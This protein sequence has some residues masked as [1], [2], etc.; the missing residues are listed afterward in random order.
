MQR[1]SA[2]ALILYAKRTLVGLSFAQVT[3][4]LGTAAMSRKRQH[5]DKWLRTASSTVDAGGEIVSRLTIRK[6]YSGKCLNPVY[7]EHR[8]AKAQKLY[9]EMHRPTNDNPTYTLELNARCRKCW[10]CRK[11]KSAF[12]RSRAIVEL[13][14]AKRS[15]FGTL[16]LREQERFLALSKARL[17]LAALGEDYDALPKERKFAELLK[18]I[19]PEVTKYWKRLRKNTSAT[20]KYLLVAE[21]HKD[22]MVHFHFLLHEV[23]GSVSARDMKYTWRLGFVQCKIIPLGDPRSA[24][25]V[26]KY[27]AKDVETRVKA[28]LGYG[29]SLPASSHSHIDQCDVKKSH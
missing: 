1:T 6:D 11:A 27:I 15:W 8:G 9:S 12:W 20:F 18:E 21:P 25:Y 16:T 14:A 2:L 28:S 17:R 26:A 22:G 5:I 4:S 7:I 13:N 10:P 19:A 29:E 24:F 3:P 23:E